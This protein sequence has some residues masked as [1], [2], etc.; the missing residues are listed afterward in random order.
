MGP[1]L[2]SRDEN[3]MALFRNEIGREREALRSPRVLSVV[4]S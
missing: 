1:E 3:L 2:T 4:A